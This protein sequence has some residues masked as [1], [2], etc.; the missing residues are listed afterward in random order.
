MVFNM[1]NDLVSWTRREGFSG[2]LRQVG[3]QEVIQMECI[4]RHSSI[5]EIRNEQMRGEIYIEAGAITHAAV[6]DAG[7]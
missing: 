5:L 4:A 3:L 1:L 2:A 6:G 7:R